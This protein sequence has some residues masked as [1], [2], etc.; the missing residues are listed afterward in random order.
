MDGV[1][2][3]RKTVYSND[4]YSYKGLQA[5]LATS[6]LERFVHLQSDFVLFCFCLAAMNTPVHMGASFN[7]ISN[8][9]RRFA[10]VEDNS[11][12]QKLI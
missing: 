11:G 9:Q 2:K 6:D 3:R 1:D 10:G 5:W 8:P 7:D 4:A 12:L